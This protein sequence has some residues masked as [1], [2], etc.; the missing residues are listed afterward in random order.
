LHVK[1]K[2]LPQMRERYEEKRNIIGW[3]GRG[4]SP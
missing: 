3:K 1:K 4:V 2:I